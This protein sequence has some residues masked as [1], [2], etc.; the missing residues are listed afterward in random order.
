MEKHGVT[1][2]LGCL[3]S[4]KTCFPSSHGTGSR[5]SARRRRRAKGGAR[6]RTRGETRNLAVAELTI[7]R[8]KASEDMALI[9]QEKLRIAELKRQVYD[10]DRSEGS[11][12]SVILDAFGSS[13]VTGE[14]IHVTFQIL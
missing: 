10:E 5:G 4:R 7:A 8:A 14:L 2:I 1:C 9:A 13:L 6:G 12:S 11:R 3:E